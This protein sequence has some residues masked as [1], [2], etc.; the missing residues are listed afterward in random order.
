[1]GKRV[2]DLGRKFAVILLAASV[3]LGAC[4]PA[5]S[6]PPTASPTAIPSA[7]ATARASASPVASATRRATPT[8]IPT[9][10][11]RPVVIRT[12]QDL[13]AIVDEITM[14]A[15]EAAQSRADALWEMLV[16]SQREP[17]ILGQQVFFFYKG[18]AQR[19]NWRGA[20][21]SWQAPGVEGTRLGS[22][23]L[24]IGQQELP[25]ASRAEYKIVLDDETWLVDPANP[26]TQLS[27]LTGDNSVIV[28]PGFTVTDESE[29][30]AGVAPG[31]LT[32]GLSITSQNLGYAVN[33]WVYTP[34]GY[35]QLDQLPVLYLLDGND[36]V[37]ER[38]GALPRVL[39][40][41][42]DSGRLQPVL[43]V[44][45]DAREPGRP[46][47]NR[48]EDEFLARPVEHAQFVALEL[49]P[50]I[51]RAYRT[52]PQPGARLIAGVSYG[53]LSAGYIAA[54]QSTV[55]H[56]LAMFSPSF[57]VLDSPEYLTDPAQA[58]GASVMAPP[59]QAAT[60]CGGDTGRTCPS[61]PAKV[62]LSAG[63]P[64][65]DVGDLSAMAE[66]MRQQ[67]YPLEYH[68]VLEGHTWS[69]WRGLADEM[70]LYFF[71]ADPAGGV[72]L[73]PYR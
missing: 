59:M 65:W 34:V 24:W 13:E 12:L 9:P 45:I 49:V 63:V 37:D 21:N 39:D 6:A 26:L 30:R 22:T 5:N 70:L 69:H 28:M 43:A 44:F 51:D 54:T 20:F 10:T 35:E 8:P 67:G 50:A 1:M 64:D 41:L 42:I 38:M 73:L 32:E 16:T 31:T 56:G 14:A 17:L 72:P 27:G 60:E 40:N 57:W 11:P 2:F 29:P 71:G 18:E 66:T 47:H 61:L 3:L 68:P 55:F 58:A 15:P 4:A 25:A 7:T 23:D 48:R 62:F 33:Y 36:F 53:G 46:Q 19:V 52:D